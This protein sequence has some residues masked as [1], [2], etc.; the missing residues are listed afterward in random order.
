MIVHADQ[1]ETILR[2]G[3]ADLVALGREFLVNPNWP[4]DA[5]LKLGVAA[6]YAQLPPVFGHYLGS[7]K[8]AFA[9]LRHSTMQT[10]I[11]EQEGTPSPPQPSP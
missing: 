2:E 10:G 1:A 5:A 4:L 7:R 8:R 6:P 3:S 11:K 9:A